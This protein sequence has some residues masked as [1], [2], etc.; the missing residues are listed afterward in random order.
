MMRDWTLSIFLDDL[1]P[2]MNA[3]YQQLSW[4]LRVAMNAAVGVYA[5]A[6]P[7]LPANGATTSVTLRAGGTVFARFGASA[8]QEVYVKAAGSGGSA[9]PKNVLLAL[10]R[11]K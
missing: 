1:V 9:L 10:V 6:A 2:G 8:N 4:N 7:A 5:P 11:T 3:K